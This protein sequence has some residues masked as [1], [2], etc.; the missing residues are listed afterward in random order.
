M[1]TIEFLETA[2]WII[3][4][5]DA[6]TTA[7]ILRGGIR[8]QMMRSPDV[9]NRNPDLYGMILGST[10]EMAIIA[11]KL[12]A[13]RHAEL[14]L[15]TFG[16]GRLLDKNFIVKIAETTVASPSERNLGPGEIFELLDP[17]WRSWRL[18]SDCIGP[19]EELTIPQEVAKEQDFDEILT[20]EMRYESRV[21]PQA[22]TIS[23]VLTNVT[24]LYE[25]VAI[26]S[27]HKDFDPLVVVYAATGSSFRFDF[28]GLGEP[29][30]QVKE[31]LTEAWKKIRHRKA[32][33]FHH[34]SKAI[35]D[36]LNLLGEIRLSASQN[37]L[38]SETRARLNQ[39]IV[40]S[41]LALFGEG[42]LP[43][44]VQGDEVV[45]NQDLIRG[46][47]QKLLPPAPIEE[48][49]AFKEAKKRGSKKKEPSENP[50][51]QKK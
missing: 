12:R 14:I 46:I 33:D 35:L 37:V 15:E 24:K 2:K 25:A 22:A 45:S 13:N 17:I 16:L 6:Q 47:Q 41:M 23:K 21:R 27:G 38:D 28:K 49:K 30:K 5:Y 10:H 11:D 32:D 8:E 29:V 3:A 40:A 7:L 19:I 1:Q 34:N 20:I 39:K 26:A 36:G 51:D 9:A 50:E 43:R 4:Q 48:K 42:A 44:E 18:L 31:L